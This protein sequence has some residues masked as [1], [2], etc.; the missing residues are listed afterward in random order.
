MNGASE[1]LTLNVCFAVPTRRKASPL[2][3]SYLMLRLARPVLIA[4]DD[5]VDAGFGHYASLPM[6][7]HGATSRNI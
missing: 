4:V 7:C 1:Q 2:D 5:I 6:D 3:T